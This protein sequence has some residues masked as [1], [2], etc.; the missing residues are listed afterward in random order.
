MIWLATADSILKKS[1]AAASH[2]KP[3]SKIGKRH[4]WCFPGR[5]TFLAAIACTLFL[6][7]V[8]PA[9]D[10]FLDGHNHV[11]LILILAILAGFWQFHTAMV[12]AAF[13]DAARRRN[14]LR[15]GRFAAAV[16]GKCL[17]AGFSLSRVGVK[18]ARVTPTEDSQQPALLLKTSGWQGH[19]PVQSKG[20]LLPLV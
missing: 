17:I 13:N 18:G 20:A 19:I 1:P 16:A 10:P 5:A 12:L 3:S 2:S 15:W 4:Q 7:S 8:Y 14:H 9:T 6:P 11:G